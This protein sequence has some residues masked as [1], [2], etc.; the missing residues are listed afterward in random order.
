MAAGGFRTFVAGETLDEDKIND[1]L[2]QGILVFDDA[3]A[4][5]AAITSPVEGQFVFR[6]D[7][8][9]VEFYDGTAWEIFTTGFDIEYVIVGGGGGGGISNN[10]SGGGGGAGGYRSNVPTE[11]TG[12]GLSA[13]EPLKLLEGTYP[14]TVGAGGSGG[15]SA[16]NIG[17]SQGN[18]SVFGP[19]FAGP[20]GNGG[21]RPATSTIIFPSQYGGSGGARGASGSNPS[22]AGL[23]GQGFGGGAISSS[24]SGGGGGASAAGG[25]AGAGGGVG[26]AGVASSI[27]GSSVTRAGGGGGGAFAGSGGAGGAGGGGAGSA[28]SVNGVAGTANTGGGGGGA[29]STSAVFRNGGNGGSGVVIFSVATG[30]SVSFSVGVTETNSTVGDKD[31][32]IVTAAGTTD[33]VTIG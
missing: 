13:E 24:N 26:G 3:A 14:I 1:F 9:V 33:T 7:D 20:G 11:D 5:D 16:S 31:V 27:T 15:N 28:T 19:V 6:K 22:S 17:S 18:P 2:M 25:N 32:Y 21:G 12:G 30:T 10:D 29:A 23:L 4:R 8:N